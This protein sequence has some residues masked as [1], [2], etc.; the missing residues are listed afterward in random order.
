LPSNNSAIH[1]QQGMGDHYHPNTK[2][3]KNRRHHQELDDRN[4]YRWRLFMYILTIIILTFII[5]RFLL[6][7]WPKPKKT[8]IKQLVDDL[9]NFFTP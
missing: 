7:I 8:F 5:Y 2:Q 9:S 1:L 3:H 6:A 4:I